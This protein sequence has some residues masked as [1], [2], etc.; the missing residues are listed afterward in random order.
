MSKALLTTSIHLHEQ[1]EKSVAIYKKLCVTKM[2]VHRIVKRYQE[3]CMIKNCPRS[4]RSRS[5]NNSSFIKMVK[6]RILRV[7]KRSMKKVASDLN[8]SPILMRIVKHE[9]GF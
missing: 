9:V 2:A 6:K 8:I 3:L 1:G 5:G 7:S 4:G